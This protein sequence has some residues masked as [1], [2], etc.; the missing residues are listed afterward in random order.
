MRDPLKILEVV[1]RLEV[2]PVRLLPGRL[3][4]PY[5][6]ARGGRED[7]AELIYSY[8]EPVFDPREPESVNLAAM[9]AAQAAF[10]YGLFCR[11]VVFRGPYDE[12]DRRFIA[13]MVENTSREIYV[14]KLLQ[15]NPFLVGEAVR[16][17]AVR[18]ARYTRAEL[19]FPDPA[20]GGRKPRRKPWEADQGRCAV[21]SSGG[22][23]SLL[24]FGLLREIGRDV[25]PVFGNES[26][27]HWFTALNAYR[28]FRRRVPRTTRVW[29]NADRIFSWMLRHLPFIRKDFAS[30][31]SDEYPIRLW[32][33]AVF[34]FGALPIVR[35]RGIGRVLVGDEFDTS[36]RCAFKGVAHY[37]GLYD[38][39]IYFDRAM[40]RYFAAKGWGVR[41]FS[42]LRPL[43]EMLILKTL[44]ERY[45]ELQV[46]QVSCHAAHLDGGRVKPCGRCEKCRRIVGMMAALGADPTRIGFGRRR[47]EEILEELALRGVHQESAGAEHLM[48]MLE[49]GKLLEIRGGAPER[50]RPHHEILK[51]RI[52]PERSPVEEVPADL[53]EPLLRIFRAHALGV[54]RRAGRTWVPVV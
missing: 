54:V 1:D 45:P 29:M 40:T 16:L 25:H 10:N 50:S 14:K 33:V 21:L 13:S 9:A 32:T 8:E 48:W 22:K 24:T 52:D 6:V 38:Q 2:G 30:V 26:G 42:V 27:R 37:D 4:A 20:P 41:Q 31:R 7:E 47:I 53:R 5:R 39:S 51:V 44:C 11:R 34:L 46:H 35:R 17:P 15:P 28:H 23:D 49:R 3:E 19:V 36:R 18:K 43:S 12:A